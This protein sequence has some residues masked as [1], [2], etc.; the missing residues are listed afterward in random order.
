MNEF[1]STRNGKTITLSADTQ[2]KWIQTRAKVLFV[3]CCYDEIWTLLQQYTSIDTDRLDGFFISGTPGIGKSCLLDFALHNLRQEGKAV[4]YLHGK[5]EKGYVFGTDGSLETYSIAEVINNGLAQGVDFVLI[6]PPEGGDPNFFGMGNL[7]GKPFILALS[8]DRNNC[9]SLRKDA[10]TLELFMG[11]IRTIG[12]AEEM[13][14]ACY[15]TVQ[16]GVLRKRF[17]EFGGIPRFL[18]K[19]ATGGDK[20]LALKNIRTSQQ[21]A[22]DD[23]VQS[24]RRIDHGEIDSAFNSLWTLYHMQ[25]IVQA[26]G[27]TDYFEYTIVPCCDGVRTRIQDQLMKKS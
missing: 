19:P 21:T 16:A 2:Y 25:P 4:L 7:K 17:E 15:P 11:T 27:T 10:S 24:P 18:F 8:P 6:D 22:L 12:E 5:D 14:A 23:V 9:Q 26:N 13:R 3:P 1:R 20:D